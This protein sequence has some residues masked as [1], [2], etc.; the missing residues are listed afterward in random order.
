MPT[1]TELLDELVSRHHPEPPATL[2]QIEEA[3]AKLGWPLGA[4][5]RSFY[6]R[7]NGACLFGRFPDY[8]FRILPLAE[9]KRARVAVFGD[10]SDEWGPASWYVVCEVGDAD[11]VAI[12]TSTLNGQY[13]VYDCWH[14]AFP[15]PKECRKI[16]RS[17]TEFLEQALRSGGN[18]FWLK[19]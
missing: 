12:D 14:E 3:E 10:D 9:I 13:P 2:A 11:Y 18:L 1:L 19:V 7:C 6:L 17:F 5:L 15:N 4:E 8:R 16:A